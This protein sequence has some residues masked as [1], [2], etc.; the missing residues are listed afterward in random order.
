MFEV[1]KGSYCQS[2]SNFQKKYMSVCF[3]NCFIINI[4]FAWQIMIIY[5]YGI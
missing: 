5:I 2:Y 4:I 1:T 3:K